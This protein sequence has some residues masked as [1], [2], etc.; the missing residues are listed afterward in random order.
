MRNQT[1]TLDSSAQTQ[2]NKEASPMT[3][4][5]NKAS[6]MNTVN[7]VE[8]ISQAITVATTEYGSSG[9]KI[10]AARAGRQVYMAEHLTTRRKYVARVGMRLLLAKAGIE[11]TDFKKVIDIAAGALVDNFERYQVLDIAYSSFLTESFGGS[12]GAY[13]DRRLA[14]FSVKSDETDNWVSTTDKASTL[15]LMYSIS[16]QEWVNKGF[17]EAL[18]WLLVNNEGVQ[19]VENSEFFDMSTL[20]HCFKVRG[21]LSWWASFKERATELVEGAAE[22]E[23]I[24]RAD[25]E[26]SHC[27][28]HYLGE[29]EQS[30]IAKLKLLEKASEA[31]ELMA[32]PAVQAML[33]A[34]VKIFTA[35]QKDEPMAGVF[36]AEVEHEKQLLT[37]EDAA[38]KAMA[39]MEQMMANLNRK[40]AIA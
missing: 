22:R 29:A 25:Y 34:L 36:S 32:D 17:W 16:P 24:T 12:W 31:E 14:A 1:T 26:V 27:N 20:S 4:L 28:G 35:A 18:R 13:V 38:T 19:A 37:M 15:D 21:Q 7:H 23:R 3:T 39:N 33:D 9:Q 6:S 30:T 11:K 8:I 10:E 5:N 2:T 40:S